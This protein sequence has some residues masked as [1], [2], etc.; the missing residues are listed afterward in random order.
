VDVAVGLLDAPDG[1][2][3]E[4]F[5]SWGL[6]GPFS[7]MEDTKGGWREGFM[8]RVRAEAEEWRIGRGYPKSWRRLAMEEASGGA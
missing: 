3:A 1:A 7:W 6:G 8:Q 4:S 2:R 5:L